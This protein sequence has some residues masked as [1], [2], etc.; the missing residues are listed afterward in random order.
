MIRWFITCLFREQTQPLWNSPRFTTRIFSL[1]C[2]KS[3]APFLQNIVGDVWRSVVKQ[4]TLLHGRSC[5]PKFDAARTGVWGAEYKWKRHPSSWNTV[6]IFLRCVALIS[7][8]CADVRQ[9][10]VAHLSSSCVTTI[11]AMTYRATAQARLSLL[12]PSWQHNSAW[13]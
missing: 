8:V 9:F 7:Y 12:N 2:P 10:E 11:E 6:T 13:E 3:D 1:L 4:Y 5:S